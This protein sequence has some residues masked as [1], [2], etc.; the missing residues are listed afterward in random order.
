MQSEV[1]VFFSEQQRYRIDPKP[2]QAM[3]SF[4]ARQW[5]DQQFVDLECEPLRASGKVL[6]AD[7]VLVVAANAGPSYFEDKPEWAQQFGAAVVAALG[8]PVV[9]VDVKLME[10]SF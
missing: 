1:I 8:K 4:E 10:V 6:I 5:L 3:Q 7:K 9:R 2:E